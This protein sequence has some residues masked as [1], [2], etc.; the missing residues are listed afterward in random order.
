MSGCL[1]IIGDISII[2]VCRGSALTLCLPVS[3]T[4]NLGRQFGPR[5]G[6]TNCR[7]LS[8]A[9]LFDFLRQ[10]VFLKEC[11]EKVF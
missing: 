4:D 3:A 8:G 7:A 6:T 2:S 11:F 9:K 5:S 1:F 10:M